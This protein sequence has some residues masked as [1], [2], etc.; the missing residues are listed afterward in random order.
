M[1][2]P[3]RP[4]ELSELVEAM[5]KGTDHQTADRLLVETLQG[6][7][8]RRTLNPQQRDKVLE[9]LN[10]YH[11]QLTSGGQAALFPEYT[12]EGTN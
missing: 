2:H 5:R 8:F 10:H 4:R 1:E 6:L 7:V 3:K 12:M 11:A 9:I